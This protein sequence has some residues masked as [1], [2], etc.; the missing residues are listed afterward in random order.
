M[1]GLEVGRIEDGQISGDRIHAGPSEIRRSDTFNWKDV[2]CTAV[3]LA[4]RFGVRTCE[5][6]YHSDNR[7]RDICRIPR[8]KHDRI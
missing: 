3:R 4:F 7:R 1:R 8:E 5:S 6:W 2:G